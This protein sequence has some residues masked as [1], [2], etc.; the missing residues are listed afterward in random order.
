VRPC[1]AHIGRVGG[2]NKDIISIAVAFV[3]DDLC[4]AALGYAAHTK[5]KAAKRAGLLQFSIY[6]STF[7]SPAYMYSPNKH[8][9]P[10]EKD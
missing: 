6:H 4:T 8:A 9:G 3:G 1:F 7:L 10:D 5:Q 2:D